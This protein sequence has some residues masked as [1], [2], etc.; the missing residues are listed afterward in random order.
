[1]TNQP[2]NRPVTLDKCECASRLSRPGRLVHQAILRVFARTGQA[3]SRADLHQVAGAAGVEPAAALA[4]LERADLVMLGPR[5]RAPGRLPVLGRPNPASPHLGQRRQRARHVRQGDPAARIDPAQVAR[6]PELVRAR[7]AEARD[8]LVAE[9]HPAGRWRPSGGVTGG[10]LVAGR[11]RG[12]RAELVQGGGEPAGVGDRKA[13]P[14]AGQPGPEPGQA[15][16]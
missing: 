5:R 7:L 9:V 2:D 6:L 3:S 8:A 11:L 10:R 1:M 15:A 16:G 4:E 14:E 13:V 12:R